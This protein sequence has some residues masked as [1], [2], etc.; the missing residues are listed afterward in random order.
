VDASPFLEGMMS[1]LLVQLIS[2]LECN[3]LDPREDLAKTIRILE[4]AT[5]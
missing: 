5:Y 4:S 1:D 2:L 3:Q